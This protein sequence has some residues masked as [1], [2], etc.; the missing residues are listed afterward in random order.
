MLIAAGAIYGLAATAAFGFERL[1]VAGTSLTSEQ[2]IEA[3]LG[4]AHGTN[5]VGLST[6]A[7]RG[8]PPGRC[9]P[10]PTS[11]SRSAC[12]TPST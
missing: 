12:P 3:K 1:E 8:S 9:R 10:S 6:A 2:V 7:A 5:L 4:L 11:T